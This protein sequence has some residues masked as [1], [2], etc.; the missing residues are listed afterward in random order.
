MILNIGKSGIE[1]II[2]TPIRTS[3]DSGINLIQGA[4]YS[5]TYDYIL[6]KLDKVF[7][8]HKIHKIC[9]SLESRIDLSNI[10]ICH[11]H[12]LFNDGGVALELKRKYDIPYIVAV[13]NTD[14][15]TY[16]KYLLHLRSRGIEI[17]KNA[18]RVIFI[19]KDY[20]RILE[21]KYLTQKVYS[22]LDF[23]II[24]NGINDYWF[25]N[26]GK[27]KFYKNKQKLSI[28]YVGSFMKNKNVHLLIASIM[29]YA[30]SHKHCDITLDI[31][32]GGGRAGKG[33]GDIK[34]L[35]KLKESRKNDNLTL[36]FHG[37]IDN[38]DTLK[39]YYRKADVFALIS[40][41]ETFG[42]VFIEA[43]SQGT[44]II[45]T[46]GQG[47]SSFFERETVGSGISEFNV[48]DF[49]QKLKY[50][51]DNYNSM[52]KNAISEI[53]QFRWE[54]ISQKYLSI[55]DDTINEKK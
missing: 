51:L 35:K 46:K 36:N 23:E 25:E 5:F 15:Y 30:D 38:L 11:A 14:L 29:K 33:Q 37:R 13:R 12:T 54:N 9:K 2:Y 19:N 24:P 47:V 21:E 49:N 16:F 4:N 48:K 55:Y 26:K 34:V 39:N 32:G 45:F 3:S 41:K 27:P 31:I 42:L 50:V 28:L 40:K 8:Y 18:S 17:L 53:D 20:Q 1:Q 7:Y 52:S 6:N 10:D 43:L 22:Q 44:P